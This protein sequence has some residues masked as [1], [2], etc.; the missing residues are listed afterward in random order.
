MNLKTGILGMERIIHFHI[1]FS[2]KDCFVIRVNRNTSSVWERFKLVPRGSA[3]Y[4]L[5]N[6]IEEVEFMEVC[7]ILSLLTYLFYG[8]IHVYFVCVSR[9]KNILHNLRPGVNPMFKW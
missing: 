4:L 2:A 8:L 9:S 7:C 5:Q 1:N 3:V 6:K